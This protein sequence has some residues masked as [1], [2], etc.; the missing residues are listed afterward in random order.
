MESVHQHCR[1]KIGMN[2]TEVVW[3]KNKIFRQVFTSSTQPLICLDG[4]AK[5]CTKMQNACAGCVELLFLLIK[6][7][8]LWRLSSFLHKLPIISGSCHSSSRQYEW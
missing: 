8:V 1:N 2:G 7:I 6:S 3:E 4:T 5:K